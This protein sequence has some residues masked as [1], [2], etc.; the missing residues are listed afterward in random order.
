LLAELPPIRAVTDGECLRH[1]ESIRSSGSALEREYRIT[2]VPDSGGTRSMVSTRSRTYQLFGKQTL[3]ERVLERAAATE[4]HLV[5]PRPFEE[6]V[7][8]MFPGEADSPMSLDRVPCDGYVGGAAVCGRGQDEG[9]GALLALV[10][11]H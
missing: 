1:V 9:R 5:E 6:A 3:R 10:E 7:A 8:E 4:P 2:I 11:S